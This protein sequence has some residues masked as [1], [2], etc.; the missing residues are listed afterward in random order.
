MNSPKG[1]IN[2]ALLKITID[3]SKID[4]EFF[5][6]YFIS[7]I[8]QKTIIDDTQGG[9]MQ[10]LV[11]MSK[12]KKH[13]FSSLKIYLNNAVLQKSYPIRMPI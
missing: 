5:R 12:F 9:A 7:S 11:G 2:Q 6:Q 3:Y 4:K 10:N 1:V 13:F 8:F